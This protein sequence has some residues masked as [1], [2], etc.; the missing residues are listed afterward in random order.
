[1]GR[2]RPNASE[3]P[4]CRDERPIH[5]QQ[6]RRG[7]QL[8]AGH[9]CSGKPHGNA[10]PCEAAAQKAGF[11]PGPCGTRRQDD[12]CHHRH[13]RGA[14]VD[15]ATR[16]GMTPTDEHWKCPRKP[17]DQ[18]G[19]RPFPRTMKFFHAHLQQLPAEDARP[20]RG[21]CAPAGFL[22]LVTDQWP[23]AEA[24]ES[25]RHTPQHCCCKCMRRKKPMK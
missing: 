21:S 18:E 25:C 22:E 3:R 14:H 24:S 17:K 15:G 6:Q 2:F 1:M 13:C 4:R 9:R 12:T 11:R 23:D 7:S 8:A 10:A 16:N 19:K 5:H 20:H